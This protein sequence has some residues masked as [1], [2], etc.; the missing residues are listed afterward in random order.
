LLSGC[1]ENGSRQANENLKELC[2]RQSESGEVYHAVFGKVIESGVNPL[3]AIDCLSNDCKPLGTFYAVMKDLDGE[4]GE[5]N[6]FTVV[7]NSEE[8]DLLNRKKPYMSSGNSYSFCAVRVEGYSNYK[9]NRKY[10]IR[11]TETISQIK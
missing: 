7:T 6:K 4:L 2:A 3:T 9:T 10:I 11:N 8:M 1:G 5:S